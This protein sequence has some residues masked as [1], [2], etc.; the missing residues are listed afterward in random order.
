MGA[1]AC[2][3]KPLS[4]AVAVVSCVLALSGCNALDGLEN[5]PGAIVD[6]DASGIEGPGKRLS[7]GRFGGLFHSGNLVFARDLDAEPDELTLIDRTSERECRI[8]GATWISYFGQGWLAYQTQS[9]IEAGLGPLHFVDLACRPLTYSVDQADLPFFFVNDRALL[10]SDRRWLAVDPLTGEE[11]VLA[12]QVSR[13]GLSRNSGR[14]GVWGVVSGGEL[15]LFDDKFAA[16]GRVGTQLTRLVLA[17]D[18]FVFEDAAGIHEVS[19]TSEGR[20]EDE[21]IAPNG[22]ALRSTDSGW[23]LF[24]QPCDGAV[25]NAYVGG[26]KVRFGPNIPLEHA[27]LTHLEEEKQTLRLYFVRDLNEAG[28]GALW[29]LDAKLPKD[30]G[31]QAETETPVL[32]G[33]NADPRFLPIENRD[34]A[35]IVN[36]SN[37]LGKL[38]RQADDGDIVDLAVDAFPTSLVPYPEANPWFLQRSSDVNGTLLEYCADCDEP[39]RVV[40]DKVPYYGYFSQLRGR[41]KPD[42]AILTDFDGATGTLTRHGEE[43]LATGVPPGQFAGLSFMPT[44]VVYLTEFNAEQKY[45]EL[46]YINQELQINGHIAATVSEFDIV[47]TPHPGI[48][49]ATQGKSPGLWF[50]PAK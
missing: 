23:L 37:G 42:V 1:Y 18:A 25:A 27:E 35:T 10:M 28:L 17:S 41:K 5:A 47:Y 19:V 21:V 32:I 4:A 43:V 16:L 29:S 48:V 12:E 11:S 30:D 7:S 26:R 34:F 46:R 6:D 33:E 20:I 39:V 31:G 9:E 24:Y 49:Y 36:L 8:P 14:N 38:V 40:G 15:L 45:G 13:I 50:A 2:V 44:G 3:A 22:C